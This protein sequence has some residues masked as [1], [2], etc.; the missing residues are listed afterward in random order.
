MPATTDPTQQ[1]WW[2]APDERAIIKFRNGNVYE[3][4]ISMKCMHGEGRFQ[5]ADGTVYLVNELHYVLSPR[6]KS[7]SISVPA[8]FFG[9]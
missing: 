8:I 9:I 6:S 7:A 4:S 1:T 5:W 3:G 2:S